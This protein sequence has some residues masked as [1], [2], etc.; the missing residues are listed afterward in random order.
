VRAT[1]KV[2]SRP[3]GVTLSEDGARAYT[4]NVGSNDVTVIDVAHASVIGS[5]RVGERPYAVALANG[6]AFVSDQYAATVSVFDTESLA[7]LSTIAVGD[8]P[9]GIDTASDGRS[10]LVV[11][12]E[13]NTVQRIDAESLQVTGS[14]E[15]ADG[16][17]GFGRFIWRQP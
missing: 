2:G 17:R 14:A 4:A 6:R 10:V 13:S 16:P 7:N 3:F 15:A 1:V 9:E 5:V 12:W 11:N 8:Y